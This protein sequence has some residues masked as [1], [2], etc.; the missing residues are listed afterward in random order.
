MD[1][2]S[3][4]KR[5]NFGASEQLIM[6]PSPANLYQPHDQNRI[7][8]ILDSGELKRIHFGPL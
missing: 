1:R 5:L 8:S 6:L 4:G 7:K 3:D 2:A